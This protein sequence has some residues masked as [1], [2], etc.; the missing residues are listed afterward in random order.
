MQSSE[1]VEVAA[2]PSP[3]VPVPGA[4]TE[5]PPGRST[6]RKHAVYVFA[7]CVGVHGCGADL[8]AY[9]TTPGSAPAAT[10]ATV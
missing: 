8:T 7:W 2:V 6:K 9:D 1:V 5:S 10:T 3:H 4:L